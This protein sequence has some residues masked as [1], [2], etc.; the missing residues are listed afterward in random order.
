MPNTILSSPY[1]QAALSIVSKQTQ[2]DAAQGLSVSKVS[3]KFVSMPMRHRRE[4]GN[5]IVDARIIQA[6]KLSIDVIASD[7]DD[8]TQLN[9]VMMD[10]TSV[11]TITSKGLVFENMMLDDEAIKQSGEMLSASPVRL[12]FK[13]VLLEDTNPI[14]CA[15]AADSSLLNRG[16]QL[17]NNV[18]A[19]FQSFTQNVQN[20]IVEG[21]PLDGLSI[22]VPSF[23]RGPSHRA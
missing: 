6:T 22:T 13:E 8:L 12:S 1:S 17:L 3:I 9:A 2:L 19:S 20:F 4:D 14:L 5:S 7:I 23:A 21:M 15:Q 18:S 11:Y 16:Q 10:R